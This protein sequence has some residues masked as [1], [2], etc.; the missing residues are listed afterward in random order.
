MKLPFNPFIDSGISTFEQFKKY[1]FLLF[2]RMEILKR[3]IEQQI[4]QIKNG[5]P[6]GERLILIGER[7]IGKTSALY[8][9]KE[10]L[11]RAGIKNFILTRLIEDGK[12]L[13][14]NVGANLND[15]SKED[16][17]ILI[18][19]P[20]SITVAEY[21][22]FLLYLW[23]LLTHKN[24]NKINLIFSMNH[25]HYDKSFSY[26]EILGKFI[27]QRLE[28]LDLNETIKLIKSRL[29]IVGEK[30]ANLFKEEVIEIIQRTSKGIPRNIVSA[31]N[32]IIDSS[33]G[34]KIDLKT[35]EKILN[36]RFVEQIINDRVEDVGLK[37]TYKQMINILKNDFNGRTENQKEYVK[38]IQELLGI[39]AN[40]ISAKIGDLHRFGIIN[41]ERGGYNRLNKI[42]SIA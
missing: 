27:T 41:I 10:V 1:P 40:Y 31:C 12:Q 13:E 42:I 6:Y 15:F 8:F 11:D 39:G 19:F 32:L 37:R 20:D 30:Y 34:E 18:D 21:R 7:G 28:R 36:E 35:T 4:H 2:G 17:Y 9:L 23:D 14:H 38:R 16:C 33:N 29:K 3:R 25:S 5:F 26:S 22:N 24:Y